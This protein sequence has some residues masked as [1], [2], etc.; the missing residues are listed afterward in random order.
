MIHFINKDDTPLRTH[1]IDHLA[2]H[3][4]T[5]KQYKHMLVVTDSFAKFERLYST[6]STDATEVIQGLETQRAVIS[7]LSQIISD[8]GPA[9]TSNAFKDYCEKQKIAHVTITAGFPRANEQIECL[10]HYHCCL[11]QALLCQF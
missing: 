7:N 4:S 3:T 5:S 2:P 9:F 10:K 8:K 6:E 1:Y 11:L